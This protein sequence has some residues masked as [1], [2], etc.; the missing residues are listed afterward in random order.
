MKRALLLALAPLLLAGCSALR[1]A[2]HGAAAAATSPQIRFTDVTAAARL[3]FKYENGARG[4][5]LLPETM[6][7]GCAFLDFDGDGWEDVLLLNGKPLDAGDAAK[8]PPTTHLYH[9]ERDGT[10]RD[11]TAG[12]GLDVPLYAMGCAVGDYDNDGRPD[13]YVTCAVGPSHLFHN[14]GNGRFLDVTAPAKVDD[15]GRWG[16]S[17]A[18]LDY[19]G[20]GFLDLFVC[21][22]VRYSPEADRPCVEAGRRF[23]CRP[24]VYPPDACVLYR[25]QGDGSFRDVSREAGIDA[26]KGNALGI[27]TWDFDH[28]RRPDIV[29]ANDLARNYLFHNLGN[30]RFEEIGLRS[31]VALGEDGRPRAGMGIDVGDV[32][33][34]GRASILISNFSSEPLSFFVEDSPLLFSDQTYRAGTGNS[35]LQLLGFGLFFFDAD[36]DG[37]PDAFV[38]NG[39]VEPQIAR[40]GER[41]T[42]R[43]RNQL[44]RNAGDGTFQD[45]G[46][47]AGAPFTVER[48]GRGAAFGD[49]NNDGRLDVLVSNNDGAPELLRNDSPPGNWLQLELQGS[50]RGSNRSA[51]GARVRVV[52]GTR[53][54]TQYVRSGSS[55]CSASTQRLHF[56]LGTAD[57]ADRVEI[58]WPNGEAETRK[59]VAARQRLPILQGKRP[60]ESH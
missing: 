39:H 57:H 54:Q 4:K 7:A 43:Q 46:S 53:T 31:G 59:N 24:T 58:T 29:V 51:I 16:T 40:F 10:F 38:A 21:N 28:D 55:Y 11:V 6:G 2:P 20:D 56:G 42:Y 19:D 12:S 52:T 35:H 60:D 3:D 30:G 32:N 23:Y 5:L 17:C 41:T 44:Y 26:F 22:Y 50:G 18:W 8:D 33:G 1:G 48:V 13:L 49:F 15:H 47:A 14:Q 25:N 36:N 9:N 27:S 34:S 45:L 37:F